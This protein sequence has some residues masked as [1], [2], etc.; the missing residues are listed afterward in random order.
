MNLSAR[1][2]E[3]AFSRFGVLVPCLVLAVGS[4]PRAEA[5]AACTVDAMVA[6]YRAG[7]GRFSKEDFAGALSHWRPLAR[8]GFA[9]AQA[10]LA[11]LHTRGAGGLE[12]DPMEAA[13]WA[14]AASRRFDRRGL[15]LARKLERLMEKERFREATRR[16]EAWTPA[17]PPCLVERGDR[18]KR[19]GDRSV[20]YGGSL[21]IVHA[22]AAPSL[23]RLALTRMPQVIRVAR[24]Q[25]PVGGLL[26]PSVR[27]YEVVQGDRYARYVGWKAGQEG[28][29]LQVAQGNLLD[30]V[31]GYAARALVLAAVRDL[32]ARLPDSHAVDPFTWEY[33]GKRIHGSV[34]PDVDNEAF[35]KTVERVLDMAETLPPTVRRHVEI[36]DEIHYNPPSNS[37]TKGGA[38]DSAIGYYDRA[39]SSEGRR[40][41]FV[42]RDIRWGSALDLLLT[43]VHEGTHASQDRTAERYEVELAEK[44]SAL[45]ALAG[46][47]EDRRAE[48]D[49]L[50]RRIE[51]MVAYVN[52]WFR[53]LPADE[54]RAKSI[55][56]E[57]EAAIQE[58]EAARTF[59]APPSSVEQS[60]YV[61]LCEDVRLRLVRWKD[62]RLL[63]G[64]KKES[65][66]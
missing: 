51:E 63:R 22:R 4:T 46:T 49:A 53:R 32:Y 27:R 45:A 58:V 7:L 26:L 5:G 18:P 25:N 23:V 28:R 65:K 47:G 35:R 62:E 61:R 52:L 31:P 37:F 30:E 9:P 66:P 39:L 11:D 64:L 50:E 56:F 16:A 59:D 44:R 55:R 14:V 8:Q 24:Q 33:K 29:V 36:V 15:A 38:P 1:G 20:R 10:R 42:R 48:R 57:C 41:I 43:L 13:K 40:I 19:A 6:E 60:P 12:A 34:Y 2:W 3:R 21:I 54:L 17:L